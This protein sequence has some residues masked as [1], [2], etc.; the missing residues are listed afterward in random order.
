MIFR[1]VVGGHEKNLGINHSQNIQH[2]HLPSIMD[3]PIGIEQIKICHFQEAGHLKSLSLYIPSFPKLQTRIRSHRLFLIGF[4]AP[5][6]AQSWLTLPMK[7]APTCHSN[8]NLV[9]QLYISF[10]ALFR[11]H[12]AVC[13]RVIILSGFKWRKLNT[14]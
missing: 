6:D 8:G 11:C 10:F 3:L 4:Q 5:G 14:Y 9:F 1:R 7:T 2:L 13:W 12:G